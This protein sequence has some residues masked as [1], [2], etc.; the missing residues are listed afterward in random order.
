VKSNFRFL[1]ALAGLVACDKAAPPPRVTSQA[2]AQATSGSLCADSVVSGEGIGS[3]RIG[4]TVADIA[5][6][7]RILRDTVALA[8]EGLP[9]R[10]LT[11]AVGRDTLTAEVDSGRVWRIS[12]SQT[13]F[14]TADSLRVGTSLARLLALPGVQGLVGENAL[15]VVA[16]SRCGLSFRVTDP[17]DAAPKPEWSLADLRSPPSS[18]RVTEILIVGCRPAA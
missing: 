13:R 15:Y 2:H 7:C 4:I 10:L 5:K 12:V 11:V 18:T 6:S 8:D 3:L 16:P 17:P 1:I 14:R 9:S